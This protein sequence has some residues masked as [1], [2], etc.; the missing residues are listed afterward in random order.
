MGWT[1]S[2]DIS[3]LDTWSYF[4]I[5][6]LQDTQVGFHFRFVQY[7]G[8]VTNAYLRNGPPYGEHDAVGFAR[9][10]VLCICVCTVMA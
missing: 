7:T 4:Q 5:W 9:R 8:T 10:Y 2:K 1:I 6:T 3:L